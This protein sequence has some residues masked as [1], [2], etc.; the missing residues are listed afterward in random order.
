M[1][2]RGAERGESCCHCR[3]CQDNDSEDDDDSD[4]HQEEDRYF[5]NVTAATF[6]C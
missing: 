3:H 5:K 6:V 2:C 1:G 4:V